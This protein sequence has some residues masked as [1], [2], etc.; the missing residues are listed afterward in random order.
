MARSSRPWTVEGMALVEQDRIEG[1]RAAAQVV[2][3][4][5]HELGRA[6]R[7][8]VTTAELDRLAEQVIR[9]A[10]ARPAFKG[11]RGFPASICPSVNEEVVHGIPG[12]R[13]LAE[14]DLIG[15]DVGVELNGWYGDAAWTFAVGAVSDESSRLMQGT[16]ALRRAGAGNRADGQH[17]RVRGDDAIRRLDGGD[18]GRRPLGA[19]RTHRGSGSERPR[20][21]LG[22]RGRA[23]ERT[24]LAKEE[25]IQVEGTVVEALPN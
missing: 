7:P 19:L 1:V 9:D 3:R 16:E 5:L 17:R 14:G 4:V 25:G 18:E 13:A 24:R 21:P 8:G 10:G 22:A 12:P 15:I 23:V 6:V 11:Y 2:A 20:D